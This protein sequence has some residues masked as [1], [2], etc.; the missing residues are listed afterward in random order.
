MQSKNQMASIKAN[1]REPKTAQQLYEMAVLENKSNEHSRLP[2]PQERASILC[3]ALDGYDF[4]FVKP[5]LRCQRFYGK[6]NLY[7]NPE[8]EEAQKAALDSG[9]MNSNTRER[10]S[11]ANT[12]ENAF[13]ATTVAAAKLYT[14]PPSQWK[15]DSCLILRFLV[16]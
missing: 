1:R 12:T 11:Q 10:K 15:I 9:L 4:E 5:C 3:W 16:L 13:Y 2:I 14:P 7:L 8:T 6:W